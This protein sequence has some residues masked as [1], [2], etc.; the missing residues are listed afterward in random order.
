MLLWG[1]VHDVCVGGRAHTRAHRAYIAHMLYTGSQRR[2]T[3]GTSRLDHCPCPL[4]FH[5]P[6]IALDAHQL[7]PDR[8]LVPEEAD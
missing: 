1:Y 3:R 7:P 2:Y 8:R 5:A 6:V 4:F